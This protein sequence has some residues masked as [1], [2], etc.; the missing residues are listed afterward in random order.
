MELPKKKQIYKKT[1]S[2]AKIGP[3]TTLVRETRREYPDELQNG[4]YVRGKGGWGDENPEDFTLTTYENGCTRYENTKTG[5]LV[6]RTPKGKIMKGSI[7]SPAG[8]GPNTKNMSTIL[9]DAIAQVSEG[10]P[11]KRQEKIVQKVLDMAEAGDKDMVKLIW[12]YMD[13]K[14]V[15]RVDHTSDGDAINPMSKEQ[16][17]KLDNMF[18]ETKVKSREVHVAETEESGTTLRKI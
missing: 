10:D 14:A 12:E 4:E 3:I 5:R 18:D 11:M 16:L 7:L 15:Q 17:D 8:R 6:L 9:R 2:H 1:S 13:G